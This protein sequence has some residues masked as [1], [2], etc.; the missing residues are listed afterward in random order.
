MTTS[1]TVSTRDVDCSTKRVY[2]LKSKAIGRFEDMSGHTIQNV[3][4]DQY[5]S[6]DAKRAIPTFEA[7]KYLQDVSNYGCVVTIEIHE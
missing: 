2:K 6:P 3:L 4:D 5:W 7:I 1:Y